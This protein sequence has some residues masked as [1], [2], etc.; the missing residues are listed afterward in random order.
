[1]RDYGKEIKEF[2][3]YVWEFYNEHSGVYPI[4]SNERIWEACNQY[5]ESKP[6][7]QIE[8]DSIDRELVRQI[9]QPEYSLI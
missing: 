1:M 5:L 8:F 3:N 7:S 9:I 4:A 2:Y 6:L